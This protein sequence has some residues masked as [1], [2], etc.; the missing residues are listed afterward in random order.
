[1]SAADMAEKTGKKFILKIEEFLLYDRNKRNDNS[2]NSNSEI[3][4]LYKKGIATYCSNYTQNGDASV[5]VYFNSLSEENKKIK[6]VDG[7]GSTLDISPVYNHIKDVIPKKKNTK[8]DIIVP[9][10]KKIEKK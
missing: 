1:M 4:A 8:K 6:I 3:I 10:E 7:D 2:S 9:S 5:N